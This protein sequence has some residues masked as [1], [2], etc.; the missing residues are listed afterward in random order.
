[1]T[2]ISAQ[3]SK[4]IC[5]LLFTGP[6]KILWQNVPEVLSSGVLVYMSKKQINL[7]EALFEIITSE[8]SYVYSLSILE[9]HYIKHIKKGIPFA[10]TEKIFKAIFSTLEPII[11]S[12]HIF[13]GDLLSLWHQDMMLNGLCNVVERHYENFAK[14]YLKYARNSES[15]LN[16]YHTEVA[17][18]SAF[19][20]LALGLAETPQAEKLPLDSFLT[21]PLQRITRMPL[22][23][24]SAIAQSDEDSPSFGQCIRTLFTVESVRIP[25]L[26]Q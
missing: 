9:E 21:L 17:E 14:L 7:Q 23:L 3:R 1:M 16:T 22:L 11:K 25:L 15:I 18:N 4:T 26:N 2:A 5:S 8:A 24:K 6:R 19:R 20:T 13:F 12:A 10:L